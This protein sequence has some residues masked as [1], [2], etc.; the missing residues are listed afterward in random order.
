MVGPNQYSVLTDWNLRLRDHY[1]SRVK[2]EPICK[3]CVFRSQTMPVWEQDCSHVATVDDREHPVFAEFFFRGNSHHHLS[4]PEQ[5][6]IMTV[7]EEMR[8]IQIQT[9]LVIA[10]WC[11]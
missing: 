8:V 1:Y 4:I 6:V 3:Y 10:N 5:V 11:Q 9:V 7:T 2:T